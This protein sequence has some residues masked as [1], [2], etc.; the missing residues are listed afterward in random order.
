MLVYTYG[1][2]M[3]SRKECTMWVHFPYWGVLLFNNANYPYPD[4]NFY[5]NIRD[6]TAC[7][8][9]YATVQKLYI[10]RAS[11]VSVSDSRIGI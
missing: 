8:N 9:N 10:P 11:C 5:S 4:P 3:D 2:A 6:E 1:Y 7:I